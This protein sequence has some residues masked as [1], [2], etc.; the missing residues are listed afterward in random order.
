MFNE[1][2]KPP[3]PAHFSQCPQCGHHDDDLAS[4]SVHFVEQH[5]Y[6]P[7]APLQWPEPPEW[8]TPYRSRAFQI[9]GEK[10]AKWQGRKAPHVAWRDSLMHPLRS[11]DLSG[12]V[13]DGAI[14]AKREHYDRM[15]RL[16]DRGLTALLV[17]F[18]AYLFIYSAVMLWKLIQ[19]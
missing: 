10:F 5:I 11:G 4:L 16:R 3:P 12:F 8:A 2:G 13:H 1:R 19:S 14:K 17:F 18:I 7:P 9:A 15:D 6:G